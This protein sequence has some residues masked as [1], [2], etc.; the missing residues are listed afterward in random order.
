MEKSRGM[1]TFLEEA[2]FWKKKDLGRSIRGTSQARGRAGPSPTV[3]E[4]EVDRRVGGGDGKEAE[5][6]E[7]AKDKKVLE[8]THSAKTEENTVMLD[9]KPEG[10]V[11]EKSGKNVA[12]VT[13]PRNQIKQATVRQVA[14]PVFYKEIVDMKAFAVHATDPW[15]TQYRM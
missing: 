5:E 1:L 12:L 7:G 6:E 10:R 11:W 9:S 8:D 3:E 4:R 15:R 13:P 14:S 2:E